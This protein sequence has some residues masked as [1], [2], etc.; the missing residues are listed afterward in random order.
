MKIDVFKYY[1]VEFVLI[2]IL[3]FALF[4]SSILSRIGLALILTLYTIFIY[5]FIKKRNLISKNSKQVII[6]MAFFAFAYLGIFYL[7][8]LFFGYYKATITFSF[9]TL[10]NYIIPITIIIITSEIMRKILLTLD[11]QKSNLLVFL[12]MILTDIIIYR[13]IYN[14]NSLDGIL[15]LIGFIVFASISC[16]ILYNNI[17]KKYG[18]GPII[19]YRIITALYVYIFPIIPDIY[20]FFRTVC[21]MVYPYL[22]YK[23]LGYIYSKEEVSISYKE[24]KG[25]V[26]QEIIIITLI[27]GIVMLISCKFKYGIL[28]VGSGSMTGA[29]NKGDAVVFEK[30]ENQNEKIG[31]II[32][33]EKD[34]VKVVHRI[35]DIKN[36]NGEKRIF[37]K[38]DS[39]QKYDDGYITKKQI[40]GVSK[41]RIRYL[42]YPSI[43][44]REMLN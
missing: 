37:T 4:V 35:A 10:K 20:F 34:N 44:M 6:L 13:S 42:G 36:I 14:L 16:N 33:F 39:N 8:G 7:M 23:V 40:I 29:L 38:G 12:S 5:F 31:Q 43:W 18:A 32:I 21:K 28:V 25:K 3:S 27:I 24:K 19:V 1:I 2:I 17:S 9:L 11:S 22:I 15:V 30:Y 26:F 41:F